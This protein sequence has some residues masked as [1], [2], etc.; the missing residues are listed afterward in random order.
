MVREMLGKSSILM[1]RSSDICLA[2]FKQ[3]HEVLHSIQ[4]QHTIAIAI[5]FPQAGLAIVVVGASGDLA[6]KKTFPS[7][8]RLYCDNFLPEDTIIWGFART[9]MAHYDLRDEIRPFLEMSNKA[10]FADV[11]TNED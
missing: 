10:S 11:F 4:N 3:V 7:L 1:L 2:T 5:A 6:K 8:L 9:S